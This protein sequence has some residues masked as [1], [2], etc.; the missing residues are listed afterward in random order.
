MY[1]TLSAKNPMR[2]SAVF[3]TVLTA[4][5]L[6]LRPGQLALDGPYSRIELAGALVSIYALFFVFKNSYGILFS[7]FAIIIFIISDRQINESHAM[8]AWYGNQVF[9]LAAL[10]LNLIA[11]PQVE[12]R[13]FKRFNWLL[14]SIANIILSAMI[15][16]AAGYTAEYFPDPAH[17]GLTTSNQRIRMCSFVLLTL[18]GALAA[19]LSHKKTT[20]AWLWLIVGLVA[21]AAGYGLASLFTSVQPEYAVNGTRWDACFDDLSAWISRPDRMSRCEGW[22]WTTSSLV[23][24]LMLIGLWRTIARGFRQRKRGELPVAW[25][26]TLAA[27]M[28]LAS[29]LPVSSESLRPVGLLWLGIVLSVL[30]VADLLLLLYEQ[31][32]L[33]APQTG[34]S[35]VPRV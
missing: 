13:P 27:A 28:L 10:T 30:A 23:L 8:A 21:P 31:L 18:G 15:W 3:L 32:A 12:R 29:L 25:L 2:F 7:I 14:L 9:L 6:L 19:R 26:I 35:D 17:G 34:P 16:I 4:W 20:A 24:P 33:P 5:L 1:Q 11:W 22:C